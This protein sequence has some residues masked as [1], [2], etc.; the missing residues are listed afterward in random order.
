MP[1][2]GVLE[3]TNYLALTHGNTGTVPETLLG[4]SSFVV[5]MSAGTQRGAELIPVLSQS[6]QSSRASN[7]TL[8]QT[9]KHRRCIAAGFTLI[10]TEVTDLSTQKYVPVLQIQ[11]PSLTSHYSR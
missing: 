6:L 4:L 11:A 3:K 2:S 8:I 1:K 10:T 7:R 9:E 5:I